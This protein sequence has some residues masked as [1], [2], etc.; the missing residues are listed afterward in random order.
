MMSRAVILRATATPW[1]RS[2]II[3]TAKPA[4]S[5]SSWGCYATRRGRRYPQRS[6]R[7]IP[8]IWPR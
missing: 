4:S 7:G 2:A 5:K 1:R 8:R 6:L 3:A